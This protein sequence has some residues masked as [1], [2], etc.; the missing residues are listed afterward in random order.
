M[1]KFPLKNRLWFN[2]VICIIFFAFTRYILQIIT[3]SIFKDPQ[4]SVEVL[5]LV[6]IIFYVLLF[7]C[8]FLAGYLINKR[9]ILHA[10]LATAIAIMFTIPLM[11]IKLSNYTGLIYLLILGTVI[12]GVGGATALLVKKLCQSH[13]KI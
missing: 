5:Y 2:Y 1:T 4:P 9:T 11:G 6:N 12:G 10:L 13:Q 7:L 8:G 3:N